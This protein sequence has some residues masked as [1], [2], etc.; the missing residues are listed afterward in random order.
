MPRDLPSAYRRVLLA[1]A[2]AA[3]VVSPAVMGRDCE[4]A[5]SASPAPVHPIVAWTESVSSKMTSLGT[6]LSLSPLEW[7]SLA[8][9]AR[10]LLDP[11]TGVSY[12]SAKGT[13]LLYWLFE[14]PSVS[15][16][17]G[18]SGVPAA[19]QGAGQ[20]PDTLLFLGGV[21]GDELS[22]LHA[23]FR[24]LLELSKDP[25]RRPPG[26]RLVYVPLVNPDGLR[27]SVGVR[28]NGND[29]DLNANMLS[30][31]PESET[32]FVIHLLD[33][34]R[35]SHVVSLHGPFGWVDYD[36]PALEPG[37]PAV[38]RDHVLEWTSRTAAAAKGKLGVRND[39]PE[40]PG[41]LG[42][43]AAGQRKLHVMTLEFPHALPGWSAIDWTE[44]GP[45][46]FEA[47]A[48]RPLPR[49][50]VA[51]AIAS[52]APSA[53]VVAAPSL[54]QSLPQS[55]PPSAAMSVIARANKTASTAPPL[56][57]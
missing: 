7:Q 45:A 56:F 9:G 53:S 8:T 24:V 32:R 54:P 40:G 51:S 22:P 35:P 10:E 37:A 13:P 33:R 14:P 39:Y 46:V 21:H 48:V 17:S 11:D 5:A 16:V 31:A 15:G 26:I 57:P 6:G 12:R 55:L 38:D 50:P 19:G 20:P 27:G 43:Y 3:A 4:A 44:C 42:N 25:A 1:S 36:G 2:L 30:D 49:A 23:S 29:V 28:T 34:F 52:T 41:S 18:V 47:I